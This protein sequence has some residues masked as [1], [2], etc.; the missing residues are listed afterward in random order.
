[1]ET[2][3]VQYGQDSSQKFNFCKVIFNDLYIHVASTPHPLGGGEVV[4]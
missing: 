4:K 3:E 2:V 1:M